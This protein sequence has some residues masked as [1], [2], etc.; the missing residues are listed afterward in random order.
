MEERNMKKKGTTGTLALL[1]ALVLLSVIVV[2]GVSAERDSI[3]VSLGTA[4]KVAL[5][6]TQ[7]ISARLNEFSDWSK[8][9]VTLSQQCYDLEGTLTAY[10]FEVYSDG[11]YSGFILISSTTD[12]VPVLEF[13]KGR[14]PYSILT[15]KTDLEKQVQTIASEKEF[16]VENPRNIYL[17]GTFYYIEYPMTNSHG[18]KQPS[19]LVDIVRSKV[20]PSGFSPMEVP[21]ELYEQ[22]NVIEQEYYELAQKEWAAIIA[23]EGSLTVTDPLSGYSGYISGIP[24]Y[25]WYRGCSPTAAGMVLGY[26]DSHGYPNFPVGTS[27]IN[28]LANAMGTGSTWPFDG[29]TWP[30][31]IDDGIV[32]VCQNHGYSGFSAANDYWMEWTEIKNAVNSQK[33]FVI[34]ML[35]GGIGSG[36]SQP[37]GDH[38]VTSAGY[39]EFSTPFVNVWDTWD[40]YSTHYIAYGN[41]WGAMATWVNP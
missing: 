29:S 33:P 41:W 10:M 2:P 14:N 16:T 30:W 9:S 28:E 11:R 5:E 3:Q 26:W 39:S 38:S 19:A 7:E 20:F 22:H 24:A 27:L 18:M 25:Y 40:I 6:S 37:Y 12:K 23:G 13:S 8:A 4:E 15:D 1:I 17:G 34:S 36:Y 35:H 32:T 31:M 21:L